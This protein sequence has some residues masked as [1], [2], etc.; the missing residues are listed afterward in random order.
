MLKYCFFDVYFFEFT[1]IHTVMTKEKSIQK[2]A[3]KKTPEKSLKEKRLAK[4]LKE[5]ERKNL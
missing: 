2:S 1:L 3:S 4:K 5:K